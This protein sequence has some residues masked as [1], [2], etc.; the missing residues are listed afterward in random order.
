MMYADFTRCH[1]DSFG[2]CPADRLFDS[3]EPA[4]E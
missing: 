4:L 1:Q 2:A 3:G